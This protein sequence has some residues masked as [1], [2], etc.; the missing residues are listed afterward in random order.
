MY[1]MTNLWE[2]IKSFLRV[3]YVWFFPT[4]CTL[5]F[6]IIFWVL[7]KNNNLDLSKI[8]YNSVLTINLTLA[9]FLLTAIAIMTSIRDKEFIQILIEMNYWQLIEHSVFL[10]I[11][12]HIISALIAFYILITSLTSILIFNIMINSLLIGLTYF[13]LVV[14]WLKQALKYV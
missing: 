5:A 10:G 9:G 3:N 8:D 11:V 4:I 1:I 7:N 6:Q 12:F 2:D 14:F 13:L